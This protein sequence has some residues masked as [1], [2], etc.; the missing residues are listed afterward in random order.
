MVRDR[1][2]SFRCEVA[3]GIF[4]WPVSATYWVS[5]SPGALETTA[6]N[7]ATLPQVRLCAAVTGG[8][9][10]LVVTVWL[11]SLRESQW[12]EA[13]LVE[14]FPDLSIQERTVALEIPKRI[15]WRLDEAGR[16][17]GIVP[18]DLWHRSG[19]HRR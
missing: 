6:R 14:R 17:L 18:I 1:I 15:G 19:A 3:K 11:R 13:S 9:A 5:A 10:N 16:P 7:L 8:L 4:G 12:L 2:V